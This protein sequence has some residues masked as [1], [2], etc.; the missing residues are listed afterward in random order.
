ML[1]PR[2]F[3]DRQ[4]ALEA[5]APG[6]QTGGCQRAHGGAASRNRNDRHITR[7]AKGDQILA[8]IGDGGRA[9]V[10]HE[11]AAFARKQLGKH[12]LA[13]RAAVVFVVGDQRLFGQ[14]T[15]G[16]QLLGDARILGG[17][18]IHRGEHL[19]RAGRQVAEVADRCGN[20]I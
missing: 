19:A 13:A 5:P 2:L 17:D 20:Q 8:G 4:K 16:Q 7:H 12:F 6:R 10:G 15:G 14:R 9:R 3:V 11:R 1:A 18:E